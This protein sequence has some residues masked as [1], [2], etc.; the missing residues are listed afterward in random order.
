VKLTTHLHLVSRLGMSGVISLLPLHFFI[1]W[2]EKALPFFLILLL[3]FLDISA[4]AVSIYF[5]HKSIIIK[6]NYN[7]DTCEGVHT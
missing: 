6:L 4:C 7:I 2:K 5:M 1:A 3:Q